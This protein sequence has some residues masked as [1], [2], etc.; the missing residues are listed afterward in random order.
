[1]LVSIQLRISAL[2]NMLLP[3]QMPLEHLFK[4]GELHGLGLI[5]S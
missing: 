4:Q 3:T 1:M 2:T 5:G